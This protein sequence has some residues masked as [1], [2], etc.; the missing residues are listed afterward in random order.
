MRAFRVALNVLLW[1]P[2]FLMAAFCALAAFAAQW[3]G[4]SLQWDVATQFAPIWLA[5]SALCLVVSLVFRRGPRWSLAAVSLVGLVCAASLIVP[6]F[7]RSTGPKAA[8]DARD[9]LKIVQFNVWHENPNPKAILD[10][11]P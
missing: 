3:G 8:A 11:L 5:G 1:P 10:W 9:T 2:A 6:E 4:M 7:L